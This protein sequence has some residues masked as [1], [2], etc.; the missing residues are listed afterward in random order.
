MRFVRVLFPVMLFGAVSAAV[1]QTSPQ[2]TAARQAGVVGERYDGYL[3]FAS[4]AS[5]AVQRE[6]GAVNIKRRSLYTGLAARRNATVQEVGIAAGCELL[7]QVKVGESY[8]LSDG[9]W[10]RRAAGQPV[11]V[12][13]YCSR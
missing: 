10:R 3:G 11:P 5:A 6:A 4:N 12:P 9:E 13:G 2:M 8:M 7:G 1:A